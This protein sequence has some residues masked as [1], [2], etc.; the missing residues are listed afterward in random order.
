VL[1]LPVL[2]PHDSITRLAS[3]PERQTTGSQ[4]GGVGRE[5][6]RRREGVIGQPKV[7]AAPCE[8]PGAIGCGKGDGRWDGR[9]WGLCSENGRLGS[10]GNGGLYSPQ[11][12]GLTILYSTPRGDDF[13]GVVLLLCLSLLLC[14]SFSTLSCKGGSHPGDLRTAHRRGQRISYVVIDRPRAGYR[15]V[16]FVSFLGRIS[17]GDGWH[18]REN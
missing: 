8:V 4:N 6:P 15:I 2:H 5:N 13:V 3:L 14:F 1:V 12:R 10:M 11:G 9:G 17:L 16:S 7:G 18:C